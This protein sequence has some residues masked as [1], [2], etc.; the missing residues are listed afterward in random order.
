MAKH[1]GIH[2][3]LAIAAL[4]AVM[5]ILIYTIFGGKRQRDIVGTW[6]TDTADTESGF[7]CGNQGIAATINN[8]TCQYNTWKL[9]KNNLILNGKQFRDKRVFA[10]SDTLTIKKLTS[11]T[12]TVEQNGHTYNYKKIL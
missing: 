9:H 6:V 12:L 8:T 4:V 5:A 3:I 7:R 11:Q 2:P 1:N 10:I